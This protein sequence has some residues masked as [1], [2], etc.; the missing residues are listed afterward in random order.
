M[1]IYEAVLVL[2]EHLK[3][4]RI[5]EPF[6]GSGRSGELLRTYR[7]REVFHPMT[8]FLNRT[9]RMKPQDYDIVISHPPRSLLRRIVSILVT[10]KKPFALW[11]PAEVLTRRYCP[12]EDVQII[13][14]RGEIRYSGRKKPTRTRSL[15][16][17][18][19]MKLKNT[20]AFTA[21]YNRSPETKTPQ[22]AKKQPKEQR[23][24]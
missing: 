10:L 16:L 14:V 24:P 6:R 20:L 18:W 21:A 4:K 22:S 1:L 2:F 3:H 8:N 7:F 13:V 11:V 17:C 9:E 5:Y 19:K 23:P 12:K 15:W